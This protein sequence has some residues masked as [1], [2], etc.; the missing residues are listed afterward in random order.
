M[1]RLL[2]CSFLLVVL[3]IES[4]QAQN[5]KPVRPVRRHPTERVSPVPGVALPAGVGQGKAEPQPAPTQVNPNGT[6][7]LP[8]VPSGQ[9]TVG[10][11]DSG[12][13]VPPARPT[14]PAPAR[15][16]RP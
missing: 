8:S 5:R 6:L 3:A 14:T 7:P 1:I 2:S 12:Q 13:T 15:K 11:L 10:P 16:R 9:V 4:G